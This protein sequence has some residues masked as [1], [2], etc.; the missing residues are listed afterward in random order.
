MWTEGSDQKQWCEYETDHCYLFW[1]VKINLI[2]HIDAAMAMHI[3]QGTLDSKT[4][5]K[6]QEQSCPT[7]PVYRICLPSKFSKHRRRIQQH[8]WNGKK[9]RGEN[10]TISNLSTHKKSYFHTGNWNISHK[11]VHL[12]ISYI[13]RNEIL[14][15]IFMSVARRIQ[16]EQHFCYLRHN[17]G[18]DGLQSDCC[19]QSIPPLPSLS[20][21]HSF[22]SISLT[23]IWP[24][25]AY[26]C[27]CSW[28]TIKDRSVL[29]PSYAMRICISLCQILIKMVCFFVYCM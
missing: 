25:S 23:T 4:E 28:D 12:N 5:G 26:D 19:Q 24:S 6:N 2:D 9:R 27:D 18:T 22:T 1:P 16:W 11:R 15:W 21:I 10:A 17:L 8:N 3:E 14:G 20:L 7:H 13:N 29:N